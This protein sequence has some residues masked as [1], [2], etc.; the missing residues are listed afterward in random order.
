M[1]EL[2]HRTECPVVVIPESFNSID[3]LAFAYDGKKES[4][5]AI[6]Q[7]VNLFSCFSDLPAEFIYLNSDPLSSLPDADLLKEYVS[8]HFN[9]VSMA[10]LP[11]D[12]HKNL[13]QWMNN[14]KN[15]LLITGSYARSKVSLYFR[16]S[17]ADEVIKAHTNP[18]FI[19]HSC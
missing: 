10:K 4:L 6:K 1:Q 9:N 16:D 3:R 15:T 14:K 13:S 19:A 12:P 17:F 8:A 18:L 5:Y 11:F 2:L 7:F